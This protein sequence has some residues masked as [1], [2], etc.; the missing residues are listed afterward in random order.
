TAEH[1]AGGL[2]P[3]GGQRPP[4]RHHLRPRDGHGL[5]GTPVRPALPVHLRGKRDPDELPRPP[6]TAPAQARRAGRG[7]WRRPVGD[8]GVQHPRAARPTRRFRLPR[9]D[10]GRPGPPPPP[11]RTLARLS[12]G[13]P[14][15]PRPRDSPTR[16]D[17]AAT[18]PVRWTS[19]GPA[20]G[21]G[22]GRATSPAPRPAGSGPRPA[23]PPAP[24]GA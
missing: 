20:S 14:T 16:A 24:R 21:P 8:V 12:Q 18:P 13:L 1:H 11:H 6:Q 19:A 2:G 10:R 3:A 22:P 5:P 7:G 23:P 9:L 17:S 4:D 15:R